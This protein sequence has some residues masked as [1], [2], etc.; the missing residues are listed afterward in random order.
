MKLTNK[1]IRQIIKEELNKVLNENISEEKMLNL[2]KIL[3]SG[4]QGFRQIVLL[5]QD[6]GFVKDYVEYD[7]SKTDAWGT[8]ERYE[9]GFIASPEFMKAI[10]SVLGEEIEDI[11]FCLLVKKF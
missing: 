11:R 8:Y 1:Q 9:H 5:G 7:R 3:L 4:E 2:A 10:A 6:L